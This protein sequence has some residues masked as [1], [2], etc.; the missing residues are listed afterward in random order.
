MLALALAAGATDILDGWA[1]R[2]RGIDNPPGIWLDPLCDKIFILALLAA[3]ADRRRAPLYLPVLIATRE[4]LQAWAVPLLA[5]R[6]L[7]TGAPLPRAAELKA[8][9]IGKLAT[10]A[11]FA[12]TAAL[13]ARPRLALPLAILAAI[14]GAGA[15][16]FYFRRLTGGPGRESRT[17]RRAEPA[18]AE[19]TPRPA[20]PRRA[21]GLRSGSSP[22]SSPSPAGSSSRAVRRTRAG[23]PLPRR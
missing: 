7:A 16:A 18:R 14:S 6:S 9:P 5:A 10:W 8:A 17:D 12:A 2:R 23:R 15:A 20:L 11:Q 1:A 4:I 22:L 21:T 19:L 13:L 3:V